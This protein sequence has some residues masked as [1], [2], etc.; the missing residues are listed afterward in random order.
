[1]DEDFLK[2]LEALPD[3]MRKCYTLM[4]FGKFSYKEIAKI[5]KC[6]VGAV[7]NQI[8]L[9]RGKLRTCLIAKGRTGSLVL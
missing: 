9:A 1:M 3:F 5:L 7:S 8:F 6:S 2:C 4:A